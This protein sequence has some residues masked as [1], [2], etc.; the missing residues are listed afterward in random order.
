MF[1][2]LALLAFLLTP[3]VAIYPM[4]HPQSAAY[5]NFWDGAVGGRGYWGGMPAAKSNVFGSKW[6][7][8]GYKQMYNLNSMAP[9]ASD[10]FTGFD[11]M[12]PYYSPHG[13][14]RYTFYPTKSNYLSNGEMGAF[15]YD[16]NEPRY[17]E[18]YKQYY[19]FF[20]KNLNRLSSQLKYE[21]L[22]HDLNNDQKRRVTNPDS[23]KYSTYF[24][25]FDETNSLPGI[26]L[27]YL[28]YK[29]DSSRDSTNKRHDRRLKQNKISRALREKEEDLSI[30]KLKK[31][32]TKM[33]EKI[34]KL[35]EKK[36]IENT[37]AP[38][39]EYMMVPEKNLREVDLKPYLFDSLAPHSRINL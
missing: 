16:I 9:F 15:S 17:Q 7:N 35:E 37:V 4:M 24:D 20:N 31:R 32:I 11:S 33:R 27:P 1:K 25:G 8:Q 29:G 26:S 22:N 3:T 2:L 19:R 18:L 39:A 34:G 23:F 10:R 36:F 21:N 30:K 5:N 38:A 12:V 14:S 6:D 28:S 13:A